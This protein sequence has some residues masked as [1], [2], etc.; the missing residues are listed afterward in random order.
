[1]KTVA[2]SKVQ[3]L[4]NDFI[5]I[6][7]RH[8]QLDV[9]ALKAQAPSLCARRFG[10]GADGI[11]LLVASDT[12]DFGMLIINAD[13]SVPEMCGN[14]LRCL[15]RFCYDKNITDKDSFTVETGAG[16]LAVQL[17]FSGL[18]LL[19]F[20]VDMG[21]PHY[22]DSIHSEPVSVQ[23]RTL[24][25]TLYSGDYMAVSMGNPHAVILNPSDYSFEFLE[26]IL[27]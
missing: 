17:C 15:A 23:K 18:E 16:V 10:I 25:S 6:D 27:N 20:E 22:D 12:A 24:E 8:Q 4:G 1:M 2:F 19:A 9:K 11:V 7:A 13:G 26:K 14:G 5:V 21:K 3:G